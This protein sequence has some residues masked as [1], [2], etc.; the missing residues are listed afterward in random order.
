MQ[1]GRGKYKQWLY[2]ENVEMP[3]RARYR[4]NAKSK[5]LNEVTDQNQISRSDISSSNIQTNDHPTDNF[6]GYQSHKHFIEESLHLADIEESFQLMN[7][8]EE[9][10]DEDG[11]IELTDLI[12]SENITKEELAAAYLTFSS[13]ESSHKVHYQ[14]VLNF[15]I[16]PTRLSFQQV[17]TV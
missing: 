15:Q 9:S 8:E 5:S 14:R 17:S 13:N 10:E 3:A 2:N 16:Y 12:Q 6:N 1:K 4:Y 7:I 11:P